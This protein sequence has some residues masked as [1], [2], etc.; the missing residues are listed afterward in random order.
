MADLETFD[1][2]LYDPSPALFAGTSSSDLVPYPFPVGLGGHYYGVQWDKDSI[3]VWG[4]KFKR[5]SLPLLRQQA[6]N[7]NV[8]GEQSIS[9]EQF[10][11]R[12]Q[13]TWLYG[14][15]QTYLDRAT[16]EIRRYHDGLGIDPWTPWQLKLLNDTTKVYASSN[17]GIQ[18]VTAGSYIYL[19]DGSAIKYSSGTLATWLTATGAT[20]SPVSI[21][22]DGNTIYTAHGSNGIYSGTVGGTTVSSYATGTASLVR[23]TKSRLMV[24]GGGKLYNVTTSGALPTALLD[25]SSRNFTWVDICG[26]QSQIYAAGYAGDKSLIYRTA[27]LPDGTALAVPTVAAELPDGEIVRSIS[28]YL[29]Y[30]MIG[31]DKGVRFCAVNTDGSLTI[32]G[33]I[34]TDQPVYC[35]EAQDHFVWYGNSNYNAYTSGLGRMDLTTFTSNLVPAYAADIMAFNTVAG[36]RVGALGT[37]RSVITFNNKRYFTVDGF[38][39]VG[40]A[41]VPVPDGTFVSGVIAYGISDPKI[42]MFVDI[43]HEP[44]QGSIEVGIVADKNDAYIVPSDANI[45]GTSDV[46]G[47]VSGPYPFSAGQLA[48]ENFQ[49]VIKLISDGTHSPILTRWILRAYPKPVRSAQW[50]VPLL[51]Y[52]TVTLGDKDWAQDSDAELQFLF[53]LHQNQNIVSLQVADNVYQVIMYDYQWLPDA[54]DIYGKVRGVFY[55]QLREIVG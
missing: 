45:I 16:S 50:N 53:G 54:V 1:T 15:G 2:P 13:D 19:L 44:L 4:A 6:D 21:D 40:E 18:C 8:P 39:L 30:I 25:L 3:G 24:A 20:G 26:G 14:E 55:A 31:S 36:A 27:V 43:K 7:S 52:P 12:S 42:A 48:G 37:V 32:G 33:I 5:E 11:R 22:T 46:P 9:P 10:W 28:A 49:I 29:G 23:F 34:S 35:F 51:I 47:S 17:T 41:S 38:G